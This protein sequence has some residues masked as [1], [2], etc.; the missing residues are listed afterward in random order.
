MQKKTPDYDNVFKTMKSKH[1]RLFIPVINNMF[2]KNYSMNEK[3]EIL[4]SEG[5]LTESET[6]DGKTPKTTKITFIFPDGQKV[7][8]ESSNVIL[9]EFT[10]EYIV[11]ERLFPYIPF[12]IAR[13]EKDIISENSIEHAAGDLE[14]FR[15]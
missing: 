9:E 13:Y 5:Y 7:N 4:S 12:Y 14:Y 10:K 15:N 8:Y 11:E 2:G 1:K 3:V 6:A